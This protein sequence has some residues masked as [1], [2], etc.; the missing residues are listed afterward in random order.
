MSD[1]S[2][3]PADII[4][5]GDFSLKQK[6]KSKGGDKY[7]GE[8]NG[9]TQQGSFPLDIYIPQPIS[10]NGATE[11]IASISLYLSCVTG[12]GGASSGHH[13]AVILQLAKTAKSKGGDKFEGS[14][15]DEK[16]TVYL[17]QELSRLANSK[18]RDKV[19]M[20]F[21]HSG[22]R[23]MSVHSGGLI[24]N[25][26]E[27]NE[28]EP[29]E[30]ELVAS[31]HVPR[32]STGMDEEIADGVFRLHSAAKSKGG[33]RFKGEL[34]AKDSSDTS[35][36]LDFY[37]PQT[38]SRPT[39]TSSAISELLVTVVD[40]SC[41]L[42]NS[43]ILNLAKAAKSQGGDKY[44]GSVQDDKVTVYIPQG[45][46]RGSASVVRGCVTLIVEPSPTAADMS[47]KRKREV[48]EEEL[49]V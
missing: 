2:A 12:E 48:E 46:S 24:A 33:D 16:V 31:S 29:E 26:K 8:L 23:E 39:D 28:E 37:I 17:P 15:L 47:L 43:I 5:R 20:M 40:G 4:A 44:E 38:L 9:N 3:L 11:P 36:P 30:R 45:I 1:V 7:S 27:E 22:E 34:R 21:E 35:F 10:R 41:V 19:V 49:E 18:V 32:G 42:P 13:N 6:A 14:V 25:I